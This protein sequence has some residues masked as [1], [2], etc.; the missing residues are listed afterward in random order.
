MSKYHRSAS[1]YSAS[2]VDEESEQLIFRQT[3]LP[4]LSA[5]QMKR[6]DRVKPI[7]GVASGHFATVLQIDNGP[8]IAITTD[9]VGTKLLLARMANSYYSVGRDCVAN[10]VNDLICI[11]ADP[12]ALLDYIAIDVINE[13]LL[14]Q[15]AQGLADGATEAGIVIPGG[16]IAQM[17]AMMGASDAY[18]AGPTVDIV[19]TAIG[20]LRN[21]KQG[22]PI[23]RDGSEVK[24]GDVVLG[25][26]SSGLHSNGYS[27]ARSV[28][29][30]QTRS[31][32]NDAVPGTDRTLGDCLLEPTRIYAPSITSLWDKDYPIHGLV[33]ISGGGLLNLLRLP[34]K[35]SYELSHLPEAPPVFSMIES[36]GDVP[37]TEMYST[38]NMGIGCCLVVPIDAVA[39][40]THDLLDGGEAVYHLGEVTD[41]PDQVVRI[42][43]LGLL[44]RG[45]T[46]ERI[47]PSRAH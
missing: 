36:M 34:A 19:G 16:E 33:N 44:G 38:F 17:G 3:M 5:L 15:V 14:R 41:D 31:N 18:G 21:D 28:L 9:G 13:E 11:G 23:L 20:L 32:L 6:S 30:E 35:V 27:L 2:G 40:I 10:N 43:S 29:F 37:A 7:A 42:P 12:I 25:L 8:A 45:D 46:F 4:L 24:A 22:R 47:E 1:K 26:A 39:D